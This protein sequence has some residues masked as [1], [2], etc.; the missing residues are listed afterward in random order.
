M[1]IAGL[2]LLSAGIILAG[3]FRRAA[4]QSFGIELHNTLM[5]AS[6]GMG[7]TSIAL[8]QDLQ[9]AINGNPATLTQ[10]RGTQ[11]S[12]GGAW[13]EASYDIS[14]SAP[15]PALGITPFDAH[16]DLQGGGMGNIGVTQ[17]LSALG[18]PVTI[19]MGFLSSAGAGVDFRHVPEANGTSADYV[20]LDIVNA[21]GVYVSDR[22]SVGG[23]MIVGTSFLDGP[24]VG[25]SAMTPD[26]ALRGTLGGS[27]VLTPS[28]TVGVYW[29]TKKSFT[30]DNAISIPD[31]AFQDIR[32]D[33]PENVGFGIANNALMDGRLLLAADVLFKQYSQADLFRALYDDQWVFQLGA[34][35]SP[36][37]RVRVRLGYA[38]AENP[39]RDLPGTAIGGVVA[40]SV[41]YVQAQFAAINEHR[42]SGGIGVR[43][44]L[45]GVDL[46]LFAGGMFDASDTFGTTTAT[47]SSYWVGAGLTWRFGRGS[48]GDVCPPNEWCSTCD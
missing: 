36:N 31:G 12:F 2:L 9:S 4:G 38:F 25:T 21:V 15:L 23:A 3:T 33:H 11:F 10:F 32:L 14:Q 13:A 37:S 26:Y 7:G 27:Y 35:F 44:A 28:T 34:Q 17:E 22:L 24:F 45:P 8:P 29:Q 42:L 43:D 46:D 41:E 6:G 40:P 1:R 48:G 39:M 20:A 18:M 16:S 19:A 30:F 5:P 47:V